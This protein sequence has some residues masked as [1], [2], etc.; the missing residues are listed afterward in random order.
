MGSSPVGKICCSVCPVWD[1]VPSGNCPS[2][3]TWGP[4][5]AAVWICSLKALKLLLFLCFSLLVPP[6][7]L[8]E[9]SFAVNYIFQRG[10]TQHGEWPQL[11]AAVSRLWS[12][13]EPPGSDMEQIPSLLPHR[14]PLQPPM[15]NIL[16]PTPLKTAID[17]IQNSGL[18]LTL[19]HSN[20][21]TAF[22]LFSSCCC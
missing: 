2:A 1:V 3:L 11:C 18:L 19:F 14:L 22:V 8:P 9:V 12:W 10:A 21:R 13:L 17:C 4:P 15:T 20:C 6:S 5:L 16:T 7:S